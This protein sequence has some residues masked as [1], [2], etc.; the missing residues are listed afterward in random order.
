MRATDQGSSSTSP[1]GFGGEPADD[2][3]AQSLAV[4]RTLIEAN[5]RAGTALLG[6]AGQCVHAEAE[7]LTQLFRCRDLEQASTLHARFVA[8]MLG[9]GAREWTELMAATRE[10][11]ARFADAA[12]PAPTSRS[13]A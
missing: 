5:L 10:N 11:V 8:A 1:A 7:F 4:P 13:P 6:F 2:S 12:K 3:I 9:E